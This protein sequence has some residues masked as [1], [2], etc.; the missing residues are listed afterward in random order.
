MSGSTLKD[1]AM[2]RVANW[3]WPGLSA[4]VQQVTH[5]PS[6]SSSSSGA[7]RRSSI[8]VSCEAAKQKLMS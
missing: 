1:G 2:P 7:S 8:E 4:E 5:R 3:G 6:S